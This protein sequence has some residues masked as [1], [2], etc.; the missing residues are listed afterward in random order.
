M[1]FVDQFTTYSELQVRMLNS[2]AVNWN[3]T[4]GNWQGPAW[5][6]GCKGYLHLGRLAL[7]FS[8]FVGWRLR[9]ANLHSYAVAPGCA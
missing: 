3:E 5:G 6:D 4:P 8:C 7:I 2:Q 1:Y 9:K